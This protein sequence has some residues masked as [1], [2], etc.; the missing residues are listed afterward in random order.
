MMEDEIIAMYK[1]AGYEPEQMIKELMIIV[2]L[3]TLAKGSSDVNIDCN[4]FEASLK[5]TE[6]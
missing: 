5:I 2:G 4:L 1:N 6:K 3:A